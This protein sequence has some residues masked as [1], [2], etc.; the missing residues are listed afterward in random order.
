MWWHN[1]FYMS[2]IKERWI[3]LDYN[4]LIEDKKFMTIIRDF[5]SGRNFLLEQL[6]V[7]KSETINVRNLINDELKE[8]K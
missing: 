6:K 1:C 2:L 3:P 7:C 5:E 4:S 8:Q